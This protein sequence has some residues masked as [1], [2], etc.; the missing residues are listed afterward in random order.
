MSVD[1]RRRL[2]DAASD[3]VRA[4]GYHAVSFRELADVLDIKSASVHY[5]FAQ[6]AD[7][8]CAIVE[9]YRTAF[10]AELNARLS[11]RH[12]PAARL[13]AMRDVYRQA[14]HDDQL[15]CLCGMLGAEARGLP[16]PVRDA[17]NAFFEANID[18]V[19]D[20]LAPGIRERGKRARQFI[21]T[22]QG[23]MMLAGSLDDLAL[24]DEATARLLKDASH[25]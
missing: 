12:S 22:L 25:W 19:R 6:K 24:F 10:F 3:A 18:W 16:A 8:G 21:A 4:R 2:L 20:A 17:V 5:H 9:D 23:A 1:T 11:D 14:L 13:R 15:H 7:L